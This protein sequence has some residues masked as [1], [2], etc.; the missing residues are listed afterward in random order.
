MLKR[1]KCSIYYQ[2]QKIDVLLPAFSNKAA[3]YS[4]GL[5]NIAYNILCFLYVIAQNYFMC[6]YLKVADYD[7]PSDSN[8]FQIKGKKLVHKENAANL[9]LV[10]FPMKLCNF[11]P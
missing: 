11:L 10:F 8:S 4:A 2:S 5:Q 3:F 6:Y 1:Q 9:N 7:T